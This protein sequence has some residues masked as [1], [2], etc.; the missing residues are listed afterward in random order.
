MKGDLHRGQCEQPS[1]RVCGLAQAEDGQSGAPVSWRVRLM[2]GAPGD[3]ATVTMLG[4]KGGG[5]RAQ[6]WLCQVRGGTWLQ[7]QGGTVRAGS[8]GFVMTPCGSCR[9]YLEKD[10]REQEQKNPEP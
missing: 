2:V 7:L 3:R 1:D 4:W 9:T 10:C 8:E 6:C 5:W